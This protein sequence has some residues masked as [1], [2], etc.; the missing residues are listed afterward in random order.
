MT[1]GKTHSLDFKVRVA[2]GAIRK[3]LT[4]AALSKKG[5][6]HSGQCEKNGPVRK[7]PGMIISEMPLA[8]PQWPW[9]RIGSV[10]HSLFK[11]QILAA[12]I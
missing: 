3:E 8:R 4:L 12:Q 2:R 10:P 9:S 1:N 5:G 6:F 7:W 11:T